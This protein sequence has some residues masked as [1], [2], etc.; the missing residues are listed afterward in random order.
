M[1]KTRESALWYHTERG[2]RTVPSEFKTKGPKIEKWNELFITEPEDFQR[3][4]NGERQNLC[5]LTGPDNLSDV[6]I[7]SLESWWAWKEYWLQTGMKWGHGKLTPTHFLYYCDEAPLSI[8]YLDPAVDDPKEACL[9]ELRCR[10]KGGKCLNT[11]APP[12]V[13]PNDE[14]VE[15]VGGAGFPAKVERNDLMERV[16]LTAVAAMLGRHARDGACHQ[17]FMALAGALVRAQWPLEKAQRLVRAIFRA[18][19]HEQAELHAADREVDST[20]QAFDDGKDITGLRT[21]AGLLDEKVFKRAK[22][23]IGL[24]SQESWMHEQA[25]PRKQPEPEKPRVLAQSVPLESLRHADIRKIEEIVEKHITNDAVCVL[26]SPSRSGKTLFAMLIAMSL[27][28]GE[29]LFGQFQVAQTPCLFIETDD[30]RGKASLQDFLLR[31]RATSSGQ[32]LPLEVVYQDPDNPDAVVPTI[33]DPDFGDWL[34]GEMARTKAGFCVLDSYTSLRGMR[35]GRDI[36]KL[37]GDDMTLLSE[38][39]REMHCAILL[40]HHDSKTSA[41]LDIYSRAAGSFA[42]QQATESQI[43]ITRF[44]QL[45]DGDT[46]RLV[47]VRGRHIDGHTM[48][49]TFQKASLDYDFV[50]AGPAAADYHHIRELWNEYPRAAFDIGEAAQAMGVAKPTAYRTLARIISAGGVLIKTSGKWIWDQTF[51][52]LYQ[53]PVEPAA[54]AEPQPE[55]EAEAEEA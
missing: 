3:Y 8:R 40:I 27:A 5:V 47:S 19:W 25:R 23:L 10:D 22:H 9:I 31:C 12:S 32:I 36:V 55:A 39:A 30:R 43:I 6:D 53:R 49:I 24:D 16:R 35:E 33:N 51:I 4:F 14:P 37:E 41:H 54:P 21:L 18:K 44:P 46:A 52:A 28:S 29:A 48:V 45:P 13:H 2:I 1:M 15:F 38:I 26:A 20:F 50:L 34:K 7:D 17:I 11:M 42:M